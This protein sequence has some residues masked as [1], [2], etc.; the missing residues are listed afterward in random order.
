[1][2][3]GN[4]KIFALE[5]VYIIGLLVM[6]ILPLFS[7]KGYSVIRNTLSDLGAQ[8]IPG[9]WIMNCIFVSLAI[10][11]VVAGWGFY[12]DFMLHRI[13]LVLLGISLTLIAF[14]NHSP[15]NP[16][17]QYNLMED[18]LHAYFAST[19]GLSFIILSIAT[20]FILEK[21]QDRVLAF[22][23][24]ISV[25]LLSLLMSEAIRY[26]G[27]WQRLIFLISFGWMIY[28]FKTRES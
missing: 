18:G 12:K 9:G 17:M 1:M 14:F 19:G 8:H 22:A 15:V 24:G 16:D 26:A 20:S 3:R 5:V 23:A 10:C 7:V 2:I 4:L 25:V 28:N 11:S 27:V 21:Q 13:A 6:L